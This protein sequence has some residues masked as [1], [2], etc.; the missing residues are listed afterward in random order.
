MQAMLRQGATPA[1]SL[2]FRSQVAAESAAAAQRLPEELAALRAAAGAVDA[3][4]LVG[5]IDVLD[6]M[7]RSMMPGHAS[8]GSD[9]MVELLAGVVASLDEVEVVRHLAEPFDPNV[10]WQT[11]AHLREIANLQALADLGT[12]EHVANADHVGLTGMIHL[13]NRFDRMAGFDTHVRRVNLEIFGRVDESCRQTLGFTLTDSLRFAHLYNQVRLLHADRADNAMDSFP[14][15]PADASADE[16]LQYNARHMIA[17]ALNASAHIEGPS[18]LED[19]LAERMGLPVEEFQR[20]VAAMGTRV[21]SVDVDDVPIDNPLRHS[22]LLTLSTGE[23]MWARPVDFLHGSMEWAIRICSADQALLRKFDKARQQVAEELPATL[24]AKV[25]GEDRVHAG[26]T[27][28][29]AECDAEVDVLVTLPGATLVV[30][31]KGGRV[32]R[33]GRRGA[34]RRVER[35]IRDIV[36]RANDQN[37]RTVQALLDGLEFRSAA[38]HALR[39]EQRTRAF[40]ITVTLERVDPFSAFLGTSDAASGEEQSWIL[41]LSDLILMVDVLQSPSDFIAYVAAR[42]QMLNARTRTWVEADA[43]GGWCENRLT[44]L[45]QVPDPSTGRWVDVVSRTSEWMND[46]YTVEA[47]AEYEIDAEDVEDYASTSRGSVKPNTQVPPACIAAVDAE[48]RT[49][50]PVWVALS[51]AMLAVQPK[52][53]RAPSRTWAAAAEQQTVTRNIARKIR[54]ARAGIVVDGKI[55]ARL[56]SDNGSPTEVHVDLPPPA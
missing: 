37:V 48:L 49:D 18:D 3:L 47:L 39:L 45:D 35:H 10:V 32:S 27:Y 56:T 15:P 41:N 16:V 22:P 26:V 6:A 23:W 36:D 12:L 8:F 33:E 19:H 55:V 28:P 17:Y 9:A 25:F 51:S 53:W 40:P 42:R 20:L 13:E 29:T 38:G 2:A 44:E 43:L 34:P 7:R 54:K 50:N 46:Y 14:T 30:E 1:Q 11:D 5:A 24:L 52:A 4:R 31:C 21:G